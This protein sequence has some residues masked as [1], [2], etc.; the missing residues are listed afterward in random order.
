MKK[1][2]AAVLS[3]ALV[4]VGTI[5]V[6]A[7]GGQML[8]APKGLWLNSDYLEL[9]WGAVDYA[10]GYDILITD[11]STGEVVV[12]KPLKRPSY[13][14][15]TLDAG[16]YDIRIR[17]TAEGTAYNESEWVEYY[18]ERDE[19]DGC[20]YTLINNNTEFEL[21]NYRTSSG[22]LVI[23]GY[24]RGK[25]VTQIGEKAFRDSTSTINVVIEDSVKTICDNAFFH[26]SKL[27]T[28]VISDSVTEIGNA[29]F[30]NCMS[31]V[32]VKLPA[33]ITEIPANMF[34]Y[35]RSLQSIELSEGI[36]SV[37]ENA[38]ANTGLTSLVLPDSLVSLDQYAF[39]GNDEMTSLVI[40]SGLREVAERAFNN[41]TKLTE[42]TF[43]DESELT[44]IGNYGFYGCAALQSV[45]LPEGLESI[46]SRAFYGC[47]Q[48]TDVE[49]P[50]T[51]TSIGQYAF[52]N[53]GIYNSAKEAGD[54][55][56]FVDD[57]LVELVGDQMNNVV[58]INGDDTENDILAQSGIVGIA[59]TVFNSCKN[60]ERVVVP[61]SV[62]YI[63]YAAFAYS[64]IT[65]FVAPINNSLVS[66]GNYAFVECERLTRID[67]I[68]CENLSSIGDYAFYGCKVLQNNE[69]TPEMLVPEC[70]EELG[71][72][73][74]YGT[75]IFE[76]ADSNGVIYAGDWVIGYEGY[77]YGVAYAYY[78]A[79]GDALSAASAYAQLMSVAKSQV[80]FKE[81]VRGIA[82]YAFYGNIVLEGVT[83]ISDVSHIG[84]AAFYACSNLSYVSLRRDFERIEDFTFYGCTSLETPDNISNVKYIGRSAFYGCRGMTELDLNGSLYGGVEEIGPFA[85]NGCIN[86]ESVDFG[87]DLRVIGRYAFNGCDSITT[88]NLPQS[89]TSIGDHAFSNCS[90]VE[91]I[92]FN[93]P[94][95]TAI[96]EG[97]F[98]RCTNLRYI[99]LPSN[100]K[101][102]GDYA[103]YECTEATR[104]NIPDGV[105]TIGN[106]AFARLVNISGLVL[107]GSVVSIGDHAFR[108][109]VALKS[110]LLPATIVTI[111]EHAFFGCN[112]ATIYTDAAAIGGRWASTWN[113]SYRP[114]IFG[115][116]LSEDGRYVVS[117]TVTANT[118]A[119]VNEFSMPASPV[120]EGYEFAGWSTAEGA[121]E[122][123]ISAEEIAQL[124]SNT[125]IYAIW[126]QNALN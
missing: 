98:A 38:F 65:G 9:T 45:E 11:A 49:L 95:L 12:D 106:Y 43:S 124:P 54:T 33:G 109:C 102:I 66:I 79:M 70:V 30:Q 77:D 61:A 110:V 50:D 44:S 93:T 84:E 7:C 51:V 6:P 82:D 87:E 113:S 85:F 83:N 119:Y 42:I 28:V 21:T 63:G 94:E 55:Y 41:N 36:T 20:L 1:T 60:L 99:D 34:N 37:G 67:L 105:E 108:G 39:S 16:D 48:L 81:G 19:E 101:T 117:V 24:Y 116:K 120:R 62:K 100:I 74:F 29:V 58:S 64:G 5:F 78:A 69:L 118:V 32:S 112:Y 52:V 73:A 103:F 40:G 18:F 23:G 25:P 89:I 88:L 121:S 57:W 14:L 8:E 96:E 72:M 2:L 126:K 122:G 56:V 75:G 22:D 111:G 10:R 76:S 4:G 86:I 3:A 97:T 107:P 125:T 13:S 46:G 90:A 104:V 91:T 59:D 115:C 31:L 35:C 15:D 92:T 47:S 17:A 27:Q 80:T 53:S 114:V 26:C 123:E 71:M 68:E